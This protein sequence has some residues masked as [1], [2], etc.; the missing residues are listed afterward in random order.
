MEL[1]DNS[2]YYIK[3]NFVITGFIQVNVVF[4]SSSRKMPGFYLD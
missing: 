4:L 3:R 2:G 1:V